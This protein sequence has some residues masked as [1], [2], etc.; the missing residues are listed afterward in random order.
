MKRA[1]TVALIAA[2]VIAIAVMSWVAAH[3]V[4]Q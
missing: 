3:I 4:P 2:A 1:G